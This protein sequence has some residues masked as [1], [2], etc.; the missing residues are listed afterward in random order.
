MAHSFLPLWFDRAA[1][2]RIRDRASTRPFR[3][4]G[5]LIEE[6]GKVLILL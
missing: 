4:A 3:R 5:L 1:F 2:Y 6:T